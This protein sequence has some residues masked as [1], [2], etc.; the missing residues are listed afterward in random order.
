MHMNEPEI[1]TMRQPNRPDNEHDIGDRRH[2]KATAMEPTQAE[3]NNEKV[4]QKCFFTC[5]I[6]SISY[7]PWQEY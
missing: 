7:L 5:S 1:A 6:N 2:D 3:N 4:C